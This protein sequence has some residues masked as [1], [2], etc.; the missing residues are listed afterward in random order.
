MTHPLSDVH[1]RNIGKDTLAWQYEVI[2]EGAQIGSNCTI[3]SHTFIES[4]CMI[5][6]NVTIGDHEVFGD[7]S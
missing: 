6:D 7:Y 2:L 3:S 1:S 5:G 4:Q